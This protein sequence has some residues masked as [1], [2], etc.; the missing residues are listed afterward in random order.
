MFLDKVHELS[1]A[2]SWKYRYNIVFFSK[3]DLKQLVLSQISA[4]KNC[5]SK[6]LNICLF[7]YGWIIQIS[8]SYPLMPFYEYNNVPM[9]QM[10]IKNN[11]F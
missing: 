3:P 4:Y 10:L 1:F 5:S 8:M 9:L 11:Q 2:T 6:K 7:V